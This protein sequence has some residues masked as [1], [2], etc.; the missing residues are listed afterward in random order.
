MD[1]LDELDLDD[2][3]AQDVEELIRWFWNQEEDLRD[4][5]ARGGGP[6]APS[7]V[8]IITCRNAKDVSSVWLGGK[9]SG[10]M[11]V[12]PPENIPVPEFDAE[13][14]LE[15]AQLIMPAHVQ[16]IRD[17]IGVD[18]AGGMATEG[19]SPVSSLLN[20]VSIDPRIHAALAH[21][22][23]W[24]AVGHLNDEEQ[25]ALLDGQRE[26]LDML[27][28]HLIEWFTDKV[29]KRKQ[30]EDEDTI[31]LLQ[32]V[33]VKA[34]AFKS[35]ELPYSLWRESLNGAGFDDRMSMKLYREA[36]EAGLMKRLDPNVFG[37]GVIAFLVST[38]RILRARRAGPMTNPS[39]EL[40]QLNF[41]LYE[42]QDDFQTLLATLNQIE[43]RVKERPEREG[44]DLLA[45][46]YYRLREA[47]GDNLEQAR[48]VILDHLLPFA[49]SPDNSEDADYARS[50]SREHYAHG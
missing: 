29:R 30:L 7:G 41:R 46:A 38:W 18:R 24:H 8:L 40:R 20:S 45:H 33:A 10:S 4:Q 43:Q 14:I 15:A 22:V 31:F 36:Q 49:I 21:P 28:F 9:L 32:A 23:I 44:F 48:R 47:A 11:N 34:E 13:E 27:A 39:D 26:A 25:T 50:S 17:A 5:R 2:Q 6:S 19:F 12:A 37:L 1:G 35:V 42:D 16:R 3:Y